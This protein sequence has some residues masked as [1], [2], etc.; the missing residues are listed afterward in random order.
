MLIKL[1]SKRYT[2]Q[3]AAKNNVCKSFCTLYL[4]SVYDS[5]TMLCVCELLEKNMFLTNCFYCHC[6][7]RVATMV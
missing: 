3:K 2:T 7:Y 6:L 1:P 4:I 5:V